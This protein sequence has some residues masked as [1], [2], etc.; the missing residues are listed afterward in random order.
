M[1]TN[2]QLC[3]HS[4]IIQLYY[5]TTIVALY[6]TVV[7]VCYFGGVHMNN[8]WGGDTHRGQKMPWSWNIWLWVSKCGFWEP[9]HGHL[10]EQQLL[11]NPP[12]F[13][14]LKGG[15]L[16]G[17]ESCWLIRLARKSFQD[18]PVPPPQGQS[19]WL[20]TSVWKITVRCSRLCS[21]HLVSLAASLA[22]TQRTFNYICCA[23][24]VVGYICLTVFPSQ[25]FFQLSD[26]S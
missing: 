11:N 2:L 25:L 3:F 13:T 10:Q 6:N 7:S 4:W 17:L 24:A 22:C 5:Y 14:L 20:S 23:F 21:K 16:T 18:A 9:E 15:F 19:M 12:V 8:M 26:L 1:K